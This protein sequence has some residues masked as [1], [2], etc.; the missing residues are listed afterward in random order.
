QRGVRLAGAVEV[1]AGGLDEV[2]VGSARVVPV[3]RVVG[4][5]VRPAVAGAQVAVGG[6]LE[7]RAG[8]ERR[9]RAAVRGEEGRARSRAG[10]VVVAVP[11]PSLSAGVHVALA[12]GAPGA[13][14]GAAD[15]AAG[16]ETTTA[17]AS[18]VARLR[19]PIS[20]PSLGGSG[21]PGRGRPYTGPI[22]RR[23]LL[24]DA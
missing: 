22:V 10:V 24:P 18:A 2:A 9:R 5:Q 17:T 11:N 12:P 8:R 13:V 19:F 14:P 6:L 16:P 7:R 23:I 1:E 21:L 4:P 3:H 15:A 20:S